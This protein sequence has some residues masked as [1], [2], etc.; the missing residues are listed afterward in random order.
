MS[1][2]FPASWKC[3]R[4]GSFQGFLGFRVLGFRVYVFG[5]FRAKGLNCLG[6]WLNH[7]SCRPHDHGQ[8]AAPSLS[9]Q[10][11]VLMHLN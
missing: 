8:G 2:P 7:W 4:P 1:P 10:G 9:A 5:L 11:F 6:V 3:S